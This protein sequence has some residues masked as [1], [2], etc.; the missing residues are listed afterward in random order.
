MALPHLLPLPGAQG[1][2]LTHPK[3]RA[4]HLLVCVID[5]DCEGDHI[6]KRS[7]NDLMRGQLGAVP[8]QRGKRALLS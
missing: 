2:L 3:W 4:L 7:A 8:T 5:P 1:P 6:G